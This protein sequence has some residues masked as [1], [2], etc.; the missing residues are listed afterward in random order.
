MCGSAE[1]YSANEHEAIEQYPNNYRGYTTMIILLARIIDILSTVLFILLMARFIIFGF[2]VGP[3]QL[4]E[5]VFRLTEPLLAPIRRRLPPTSGLDLS[6]VILIFG[7]F[8]I[9]Q[10]LLAL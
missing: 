8:L 5:W 1:Q 10:L 3:Y 7:L 9:R 4:K 2:N 6:P